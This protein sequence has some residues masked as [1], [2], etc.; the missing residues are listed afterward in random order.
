MLTVWM[1]CG[2]ETTIA[3]IHQVLR[4][5]T[6]AVLTLS[7]HLQQLKRVRIISQFL[8]FGT[9]LVLWQYFSGKKSKADI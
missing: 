4:P 9:P 6:T 1:A 8:Y 5:Q 2:V 3:K 7:P